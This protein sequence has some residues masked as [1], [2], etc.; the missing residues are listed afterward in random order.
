M[1]DDR[2]S[3]E[4]SLE[5]LPSITEIAR[6]HAETHIDASHDSEHKLHEESGEVAGALVSTLQMTGV[7]MDFNG[8]SVVAGVL[9]SVLAQS[10]EVHEDDES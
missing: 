7:P 10:A 8:L 3:R 1:S 5:L 4:K 2:N 6:G 9:L